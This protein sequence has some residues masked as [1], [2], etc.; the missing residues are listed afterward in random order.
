MINLAAKMVGLVAWKLNRRG[1]EISRDSGRTQRLSVKDCDSKVRITKRNLFLRFDL[2]GPGLQ[3]LELLDE[4]VIRHADGAL[5]KA[6]QEREESAV[7]VTVG[8]FG[9][10]DEV[11]HQWRG[12][13]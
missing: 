12:E 4:V 3:H 8:A 13:E 6:G 10:A 9:Q 1:Q 5:E 7:A 11:D 2:F